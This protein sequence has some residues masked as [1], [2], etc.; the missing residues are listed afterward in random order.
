MSTCSQTASR[1]T[2]THLSF[3]SILAFVRYLE[4]KTDADLFSKLDEFGCSF[5]VMRV[6]DSTF[7]KR[8]AECAGFGPA[9]VIN[10]VGF[11]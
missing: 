3:I 7:Q 6:H 4:L 2:V 8:S 5:H 10:W 9:V 1:F 11:Q